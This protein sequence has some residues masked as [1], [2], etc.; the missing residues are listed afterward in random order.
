LI[1]DHVQVMEV[2]HTLHRSRQEVL[3]PLTDVTQ[4]DNPEP[5]HQNTEAVFGAG[6]TQAKAVSYASMLPFIC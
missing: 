1:T 5:E 3:P 4:D 6:C 2:L